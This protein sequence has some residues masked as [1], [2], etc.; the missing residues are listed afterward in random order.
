MSDKRGE[1]ASRALAA[2]AAFAAAYG[3]RKLVGFG[4]KKFTGK[5]PPSDLHDPQVAFREALTWAVLLGVTI[6]A[7]R[8]VAGRVATRNIRRSEDSA[9]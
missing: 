3:A 7:A 4:W 1:G 2:T 9:R 8:L 5:E 6:E